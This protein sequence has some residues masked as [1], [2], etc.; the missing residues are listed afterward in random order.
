MIALVLLAA[1][2]ATPAPTVNSE[3]YTYAQRLVDIGDG[4]KLNLYCI[5]NGSPTVIFDSGLDVGSGTLSWN[6]VQPAVARFT[7]ACSYDRAGYGFS[8]PGPLPRTSNAVVS[9]LRAL[10]DRAGIEPPYILV[11]HSIAGLYEPLFADRYPSDV[12]GMVLVDPSTAG[13]EELFSSQFPKYQAYEAAQSASMHKCAD[14]PSQSSCTVPDDPHLSATLNAT[15]HAML[16][17]AGAWADPASELDSVGVDGAEVDAAAHG[18]STMPL[19]VLTSVSDFK[20]IQQTMGAT[21]SQL[22][23]AQAGWVSLHDQLAAQSTRGVNC[24]IA[25]AGH[26]IQ[27]DKPDVVI[28]AIRQVITLLTQTTAKPTCPASASATS[29]PKPAPQKSRSSQRR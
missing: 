2:H 12:V 16:H 11:G 9:D 7:R 22:A 8:D 15:I 27:T 13:Q 17:T 23:T 14:D 19:I 4:R 5:G 1:L 3:P 24:V 20:N 29:H 6:R 25:G 10:L 18:Y 21:S 26:F 28:D